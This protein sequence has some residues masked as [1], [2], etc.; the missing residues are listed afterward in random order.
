MKPH[1]FTNSIILAPLAGV[2]DIP[3]RRICQELGSGFTFVEMISSVALNYGNKRTLQMM[4][5]H[6]SESY[7]GIQITG[8]TVKDMLECVKKINTFDTLP[9]IYDWIDINM[10]CPVRKVVQ[11]GCGSGFLLD[12]Q[13]ITDTLQALVANSA[14]PISAKIRLGWTH[15]QISVLDTVRR[16]VEAGVSMVTIHGR[17][18]NDSYA[19][20]VQYSWI[21]K[22][23]ETIPASIYTVGNGNVFDTQSAIMMWL[24]TA[25]QGLMVSRGALGNPWIFT[26]LKPMATILE[27]LS[28]EDRFAQL[29]AWSKEP[30][31]DY[32]PT[33]EEW[34]RVVK[35]HI[36]YQIE[37]YGNTP[38][39]C[40]LMRKHFIWYA[41]G[42]A[43]IKKLR[44]L[45]SHVTS[46]DEALQYIQEFVD[47]TPHNT[48]RFFSNSLDTSKYNPHEAMDRFLDRGVGHLT[49]DENL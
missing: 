1:L 28:A 18:R 33:I 41:S 20:P 17:T 43:D 23:V 26:S 8:P 10:G 48:V 9:Y 25:C 24:Q 42:F 30:P 36:G 3:F 22:A 16:C 47:H 4:E 38:L 34:H 27:N 31:S 32:A 5:R 29:V 37:T 13:R 21:H 6:P 39:A 14:I 46:L 40:T 44:V 35:Q 12:P 15:E 2:S 19:D 11:N 45:L 7:L 49:Q